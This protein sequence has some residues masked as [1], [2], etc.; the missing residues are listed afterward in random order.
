MFQ[1]K[2]NLKC[3]LL[4]VSR[5]IIIIKTLN[6]TRRKDQE[7]PCVFSVT[8]DGVAKILNV[9]LQSIIGRLNK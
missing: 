3:F 5:L 7:F 4:D 1:V 6:E 8:M 2:A 9:S